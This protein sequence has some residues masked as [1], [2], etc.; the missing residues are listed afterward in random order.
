MPYLRA[1]AHDY[2]EE[3][4]GGINSDI[5]EGTD[6]RQVQALTEEV[7][8]LHCVYSVFTD[9]LFRLSKGKSDEYLKPYILGSTFLLKRGYWLG[10]SLISLTK[11]L[12]TGHGYPGYE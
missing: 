11:R 8:D 2:Y 12:T 9:A 10:M 5:L 1:K 7:S 4:G 3:L 6:T